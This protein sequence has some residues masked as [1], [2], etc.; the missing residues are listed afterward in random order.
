MTALSRNYF[1]GITAIILIMLAFGCGDE[2][3]TNPFPDEI[4]LHHDGD[5]F[6]AP[7]LGA[8]TYQAAARFSADEIKAWSGMKVVEVRYFF[9]EKPDQCKIN[10]YGAN[11]DKSPGQLLYSADVGHTTNAT[12]WNIHQLSTPVTVTAS[13]LWISIEFEQK[14]SL[15]SIGCDPGPNVKD[16]DWLFSSND[17]QWRAFSER[18]N[19]S[20]NWNIRA[21]L[22]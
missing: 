22:K 8:G 2:N 5:N 11:S 6:T 3:G 12:S 16:G 13:D 15:K 14:T 9:V 17:D 1:G 7:N 19:A 21:L 20:I 4:I 18:T 10:I